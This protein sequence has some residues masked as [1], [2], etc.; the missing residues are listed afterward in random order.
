MGAP[1][2]FPVTEPPRHP[3]PRLDRRE[4]LEALAWLWAAVEPARPAPTP[5]SPD[6]WRDLPTLAEGHGLAALAIDAA[7]ARSTGMDPVV[8]EGLA[9]LEDAAK[10]TVARGRRLA[11]EQAALDA[12]LD[13]AELP[14]VWLKGSWFSGEAVYPDPLLRPRAD[15]D[16]YLPE[17][18]WGRAAAV[19]EGLGYRPAQRSWKHAVWLSAD[20]QVVD[21]RGE[22]PS[23]PR[24]VELH[25]HLG[26]G[27]RGLRLDL[28]ADAPRPPARR[29]SSGVALTHLAAHATV[30]MLE[31]RLRLVQL[32]DLALLARRLAPEDEARTTMIGSRPGAARFLWPS[33]ALTARLSP[34]PALQRLVAALEPGVAA[35]LRRW[36]DAQDVDLLSWPG[37]DD[38]RRPLLEI[39]GIW[40]A[41]AAEQATVWRA[42]LAP[43][44]ELL[45][46]RYPELAA[47][48]RRTAMVLR[49]LGFT[50]RQAARRWR[51]RP[52]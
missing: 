35:P 11:D 19:L 40:P 38:A 4:R 21:L 13:R 47:E 9:R 1:S 10:R 34:S 5:P 49:H 24:P 22:H 48:G 32:L 37:R 41:G 14:G 3:A 29:L 16:L 17:A 31:R 44:P 42:I 30:S 39:P 36:L 23:N 8:L 6:L 28:D 50:A 12:A 46:D 7:R 43:P 20:H 33:L 25:P 27:F 26:E 2:A 45:A 18:L 15:L 51:Q 52:R